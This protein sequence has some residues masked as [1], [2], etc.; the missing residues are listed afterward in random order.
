MTSVNVYPFHDDASAQYRLILPGKALI[1]AGHDVII[2]SP[3]K[4][5]NDPEYAA[6]IRG[7]DVAVLNR[8]DSLPAVDFI[9]QLQRQGTKVLVDMDDLLGN[10]S[11]MHSMYGRA[12]VLHHW[13]MLACDA[14]DWVTASTLEVAYEYGRNN[15]FGQRD[16]EVVWNRVPAW[17]LQLREERSNHNVVGWSGTVASHPLDLLS[18]GGAVGRFLRR[19]PDWSF[20]LVGAVE[21]SQEVM[22]QL[23]ISRQ[24]RASGWVDFESYPCWLAQ[25]D[26]GI[27]PLR[28]TRFNQ[29]KSWLKALEMSAV[30]CNVVMADTDENKRLYREYGIGHPAKNPVDWDRQLNL[31]VTSG[32]RPAQFPLPLTIEGALDDWRE[33]WGL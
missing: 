15:T 11:P 2:Y 33:A 9:Y 32:E 3:E 18:T 17:Y 21:E 1:A 30:G 16:A 4:V 13:A 20:G 6:S 12:K 26:I 14:A 22:R 19:H 5:I 23:S 7:S 25:F 28:P 10:V 29:G 8:P 27:V 24:I 31:L